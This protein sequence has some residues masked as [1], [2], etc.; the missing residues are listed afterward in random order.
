MSNS[1]RINRVWITSYI[2]NRNKCTAIE[3][4]PVTTVHRSY[5]LYNHSMKYTLTWPIKDGL[6]L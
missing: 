3:K 1:F 4:S 5:P 2:Y 6:L